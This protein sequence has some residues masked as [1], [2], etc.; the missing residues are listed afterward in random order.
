MKLTTLKTYGYTAHG[1][2]IMLNKWP[3]ATRASKSAQLRVFK[4]QAETLRVTGP[5]AL[6][7][8]MDA[9]SKSA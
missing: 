8:W 4:G 2:M 5:R 9:M 1:L 3:G 7:S 6:L